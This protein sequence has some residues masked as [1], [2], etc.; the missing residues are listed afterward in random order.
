MIH[1]ICAAKKPQRQWLSVSLLT[2]LSFPAAV[3][4][5][6]APNSES[7]PATLTPAP[8]LEQQPA[9]LPTV[10]FKNGELTIVAYNASL[11]DIME[12]VRTQTGA[13][14][15]IPPEATERVFVSLGPG[16]TRRILDSLLAGSSF[17]YV[18]LGSPTD[19]QAL[20][21][22]VLVPKPAENSEDG[23][24]AETTTPGQRRVQSA[25]ARRRARPAEDAENVPVP[26]QQAQAVVD[27]TPSPVVKVENATKPEPQEK[28]ETADAGPQPAAEGHPPV[29]NPAATTEYPHTPNIKTAQ[30]VLQD[31]YARR[32]AMQ[33]RQSGA[34]Q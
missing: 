13:T 18:L 11:R 9:Q 6:T 17:N 26:V 16:P 4:S 3:L 21:K 5:Q 15:E 28:V 10:T 33:Q 23:T 1:R 29:E 34:P 24:V 22:V 12:M 25:Y 14:I 32:Q 27:E 8:T 7:N 30:Q 2:A 31:L 19:S 20:T